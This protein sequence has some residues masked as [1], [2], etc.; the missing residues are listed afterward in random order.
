MKKVKLIN[1]HRFV[2]ETIKIHNSVLLSGENGAGK[3][4]ILDAIQL[5]LTCSKSH[6]NKA[7]NEKSKRNLVGYVRYKTGKKKEK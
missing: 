4:T 3:S 1:W 5:V 7:A 2:N 6:F